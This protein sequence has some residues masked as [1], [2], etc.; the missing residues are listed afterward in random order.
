M[1]GVCGFFQAAP[2]ACQSV[3]AYTI[4][5]AVPGSQAFVDPRIWIFSRLRRCKLRSHTFHAPT[6]GITPLSTTRLRSLQV[7]TVSLVVR[8]SALRIQTAVR[9]LA[10]TACPGLRAELANLVTH[11][12]P[13]VVYVQTR[14]LMDTTKGGVEGNLGKNPGGE[15][16]IGGGSEGGRW[17]LGGW[18]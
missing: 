15:R 4:P 11:E 9:V 17:V 18:P 5:L 10:L 8:S 3:H 1:A 7:P 6:E 13:L 2:G 14:N 16:D 12:T